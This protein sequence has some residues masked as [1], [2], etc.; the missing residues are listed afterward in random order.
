MAT[1]SW[2]DI[3]SFALIMAIIQQDIESILAKS[4]LQSKYSLTIYNAFTFIAVISTLIIAP[5]SI[6]GNWV[7]QINKHIKEGFL[8]YYVFHGPRRIDDPGC[9]LFKHLNS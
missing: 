5:M 3:E 1:N 9:K 6:L 2:T 7:D 4:I 8:T